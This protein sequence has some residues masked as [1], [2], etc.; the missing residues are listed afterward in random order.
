[1]GQVVPIK[2]KPKTTG[3]A[4]TGVLRTSY[5]MFL[6]LADIEG[7]EAHGGCPLVGLNKNTQRALF[8]RGLIAYYKSHGNRGCLSPI[9]RNVLRSWRARLS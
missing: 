9:G 8:R 7:M 6:M 4:Q 2:P 3:A 5:Q 1:M